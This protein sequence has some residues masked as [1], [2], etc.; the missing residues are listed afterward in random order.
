MLQGS[1][2]G[3]RSSLSSPT[4]VVLRS[5]GVRGRVPDTYLEAVQVREPEVLLLHLCPC[6]YLVHGELHV[7]EGEEDHSGLHGSILVGDGG[8]WR[9]G[10]HPYRRVR[11]PTSLGVRY[12]HTEMGVVRDHASTRVPLQ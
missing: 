10:R 11:G 4:R 8:W 2:D 12:V 1:C 7:W 5:S 3:V 9:E 6:F